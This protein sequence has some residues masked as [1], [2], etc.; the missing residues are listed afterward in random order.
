MSMLPNHAALEVVGLWVALHLVLI[1][2][3]GLNV[4]RLRIKHEVPL[5]DGGNAE[6]ARAIRAHGNAAEF[7]PGLLV[8]LAIMALVGY[9]MNVIHG[10]GA[11]LFLARLLHAVGIQQDAPLPPLRVGGNILTW[12]VTLGMA[13]ALI[14]E[15]VD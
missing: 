7:V 10:F 4:T 9:G 1:W 6:L 14:Y 8:A 5:G 15:F 11:A 13:G 3:L 2:G 12:L